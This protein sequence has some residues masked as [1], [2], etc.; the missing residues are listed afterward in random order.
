MSIIIF[1]RW[2]ARQKLAHLGNTNN[3]KISQC[4]MLKIGTSDAIPK[5]KFAK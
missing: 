5:S 2:N 4:T 3:K 1:I